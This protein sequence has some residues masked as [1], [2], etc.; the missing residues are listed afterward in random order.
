MKNEKII[1]S[2]EKYV[3]T[4]AGEKKVF[5]EIALARAESERKAVKKLYSAESEPVLEL[6]AIVQEL[7]AEMK[8]AE[9]KAACGASL[10][11]RTK[12]L[13][14]LLSKCFRENFQKAFFDEVYGVKMQCC[15]IDGYYGFMFKDA[16]NHPKECEKTRIDIDEKLTKAVKEW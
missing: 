11:K 8:E 1:A 7:K 12:L 15:I 14:K 4:L 9:L 3:S 13:N 6:A 2:I 5:F 10:V 16:R